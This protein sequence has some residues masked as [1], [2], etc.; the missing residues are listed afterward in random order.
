MKLVEKKRIELPVIVWYD[1]MASDRFPGKAWNY[2]FRD[3]DGN[4]YSW[5]TTTEPEIYASEKWLVKMTLIG[6]DEC[7]GF[8]SL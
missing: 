3:Q 7:L 1:H 6:K 8:L 2:T 4:E 5:D